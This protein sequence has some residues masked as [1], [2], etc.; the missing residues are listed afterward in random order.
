MSPVS[1]IAREGNQVSIPCCQ[2]SPDL[3]DLP[4]SLAGKAR[5]LKA[6]RVKALIKVL[7]VSI[8][9]MDKALNEY[10]TKGSSISTT[11]FDLLLYSRGR[12]NPS[13]YK[14]DIE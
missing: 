5:T 2:G 12:I 13:H 14:S 3:C 1:Q 7:A 11:T 10:L 9:F 4:P 8:L 6:S